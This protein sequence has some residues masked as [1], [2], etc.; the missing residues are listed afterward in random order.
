MGAATRGFSLLVPFVA[1]SLLLAYGVVSLGNASLPDTFL[2]EGIAF[3]CSLLLWRVYLQ[4]R[5]NAQ[6]TPSPSVITQASSPPTL[7]FNTPYT[8]DKLTVTLH[9]L[10]KRRSFRPIAH[11]SASEGQVQPETWFIEFTCT[12]KNRA[13]KEALIWAQL[14][15]VLPVHAEPHDPLCLRQPLPLSED[16][17]A[18]REIGCN[19]TLSS[20]R[21]SIVVKD[22]VESKLFF[23]L[24]ESMNVQT[25]AFSLHLSRKHQEPRQKP[26]FTVE[27]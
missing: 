25:M 16:E 14:E 11:P 2:S 27:V 7:L 9:A 26:L 20:A 6:R 21:Y 23:K 24:N 15:E 10:R 22:T 8:F 3:V 12:L 13:R 18:D 5:G 4:W 1:G 19:T 17:A